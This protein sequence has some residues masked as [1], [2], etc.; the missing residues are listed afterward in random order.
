MRWRKASAGIFCLGLLAVLAI[1]CRPE[2]RQLRFGGGPTGGTYQVYAEGLAGLLRQALQGTLVRVERTGGS[3][4]NLIEVQ[5]GKL[6]M[7]LVYA[8]DAYFGARGRLAPGLPPQDRV[9]GLASVYGA[10]A[11]LA[12][13]HQSS[14]RS[15]TDLRRRRVAVGNPGSGAAKSAERYFRAIGIW[16]QIIPVYLGYSMAL[17]DLKLRTVDAVWELVGYPSASLAAAARRQHLRLL[18]LDRAARAAGFYRK[19]PFYT[20]ARIPAETYRGQRRDVATFQ[21]TALWVARSGLDKDLVFRSLSAVFSEKGLQR[22]RGVHPAARDMQ[23]E[24]GLDGM[25][26]PLHPGARRF[27]QSQGRLRR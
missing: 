26:I 15:V 24:K 22:M 18:D 16:N 11:H 6:D 4:D 21:D 10:P 2:I 17:N 1:G 3:V 13:L 25:S 23:K 7:G 14:I 19:Y 8:G 9:R 12:V 27:W 5:E 20:P